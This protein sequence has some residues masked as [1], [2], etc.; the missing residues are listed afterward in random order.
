MTTPQPLQ[1]SNLEARTTREKLV[2][3]LRPLL[4]LSVI[5]LAVVLAGRLLI[6]AYPA[7]EPW[8][9][10]L[11]ALPAAW[12]LFVLRVLQRS[13]YGFVEVVIGIFTVKYTYGLGALSEARTLV[14]LAAAIYVIIRG[15]DNIDQG[16]KQYCAT[17]LN[18]GDAFVLTFY[19]EVGVK[20]RFLSGKEQRSIYRK[21]VTPLIKELWIEFDQMGI[22]PTAKTGYKWMRKHHA[23]QFL[24]EGAIKLCRRLDRHSS[25]RNILKARQPKR[26]QQHQT[27]PTQ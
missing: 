13:I 18:P 20:G 14:P 21:M 24:N 4:W 1:V 6:N 19:W 15:L 23:L 2:D 25:D 7:I 3:V 17:F 22:E 10:A 12:A 9:F 27:R 26:Q 8:W 16:L 5:A 11:V